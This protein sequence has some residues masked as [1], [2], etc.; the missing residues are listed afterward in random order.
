MSKERMVEDTGVEVGGSH[1]SCGGFVGQG[2]E[3]DL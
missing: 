3:L 1:R 2:E